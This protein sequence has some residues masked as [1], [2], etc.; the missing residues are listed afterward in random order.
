MSD[1]EHQDNR[2]QVVFC[3]HMHQP[4]YKGPEGSDYL[5]P[6]VYLHGL[7]DY[8]DMAAHL[9]H[10]PDAKAVVNFAPVLLE[11]IDDYS[12][13]IAAWLKTGQLIK[14][15]LLAALAGPGLPVDEA[16]RKELISAC[17]RANEHRLISRFKHFNELAD[18]VK[19]TL[20]NDRMVGY[21]NDQCLVDLLV[22]YHLAWVG[23]CQRVN[24]LR[25]R[26]L[27]AKGRGFNSDDRRRLM[28]LIG[29]VLQGLPG[30]YA[31]LAKS[32]QVEL[33]VTPY[34]HPIVPLMI[35][36][37]SAKDALP[38]IHMPDLE[39]YPGGESRARWH[40][41]KGLEVFEKHFGFRPK[42]CWPS[43]G[44]VSEATLKMLE[45]EGFNWAATGQQ[46]LSNSLMAGGGD[47][48]LPD[49]WV[50]SAYHVQEGHLNMFFRDDGLSDLIGFTYGEW[51][52]DDAV[53]DLINHLVNIADSCE[54]DPDAV[55]SIIMD[56]EN[57]WEYYPYNGSYFLNAMYE[58]LSQH[59]R[60]RLTTFSEVLDRQ[61][62]LSPRLSKLVAGSWVYGTFTTW[63]GDRDKNR[64]WDMLVEAKK[65]YD[66]VLDTKNFSD[67][68]L[69]EI[70]KQ[71]A[72]CEGSDWFWWFGDYNPESTVSDFEQLFRSQL[73]HLFE[74]L[75]EP[76][77]DYLSEVFAVGSGAPV[78]GGVM[79]KN[80]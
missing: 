24:D 63:I 36:M 40:M 64:A 13:Q 72:I 14:D 80:D 56:G 78:Q 30:R 18:L 74:L 22:W 25:V 51:H 19:H 77:P 31:D 33:S 42:G 3:W 26:S 76:V 17:L 46:V 8:S 71:L 75:G 34:A 23:E 73:S 4:Y 69:R 47:S 41:R 29:E 55:V 79:K 39:Q 62:K 48:Q 35:D 12:E 1:S 44:G 2:L 27:Q 52:A 5:L 15:P 28:E 11:Q 54:G 38:T 65:V 6:W 21:L 59:P 9:E 68:Q 61:K 66:Q 60:L 70:E 50:H 67:D 49:N 20:E 10:V 32:G 16:Y 45:E 57:A 37:D 58:R 7:K 43:E 53:G